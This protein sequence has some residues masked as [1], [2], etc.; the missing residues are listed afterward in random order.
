MSRPDGYLIGGLSV[1]R[2]VEETS[3]G[4]VSLFQT[5]WAMLVTAM[6]SWPG[7]VPWLLCAN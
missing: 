5:S 7:R 1:D 6:W 2:I 4:S 3:A